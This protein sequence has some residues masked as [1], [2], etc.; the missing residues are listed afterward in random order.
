MSNTSDPNHGIIDHVKDAA[1]S[2]AD[3]AKDLYNK[4][5]DAVKPH[6][7]TAAEKAKAGAEKTAAAGADA[8]AT[9]AEKTAAGFNA[10]AAKISGD[11]KPSNA[12]KANEM[13]DNVT[14]KAYHAAAD[15]KKKLDGH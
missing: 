1:Q 14:D 7:E 6:E 10:A 3:G 12:E 15:A 2:A 8:T 5:A 4:A 11:D 9:A 13:A